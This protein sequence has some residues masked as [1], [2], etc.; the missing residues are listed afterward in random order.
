LR[1]GVFSKEESTR[2]E[3]DGLL[4]RVYRSHSTSAPRSVPTTLGQIIIDKN[5][6][7]TATEI[8]RA[9]KRLD[10]E[11]KKCG[12]QGDVTSGGF[13]YTQ[14]TSELARA[15]Q[16]QLIRE[17]QS[18]PHFLNAQA[19]G[20]FESV[21]IGNAQAR[22]VQGQLLARLQRLADE[23]NYEFARKH[24]EQIRS[25]VF[26][27]A[28]AHEAIG[29]AYSYQNDEELIAKE[30]TLMGLGL[31]SS[32]E[33][34]IREHARESKA[35][36]RRLDRVY[37]GERV[38]SEDGEIVWSAHGV[39]DARVHRAAFGYCE[40][41][42]RIQADYHQRAIIELDNGVIASVTVKRAHSDLEGYVDEVVDN[43]TWY[44]QQ[45][46]KAEQTEVA[47]RKLLR[48]WVREHATATTSP[49]SHTESRD[50]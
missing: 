23:R 39:A 42:A 31:P 41:A 8:A 30:A 16:A 32:H 44:R 7:P 4:Q 13:A 28:E 12:V 50:T 38:V 37:A 5:R 22:A 17:R 35:L 49:T 11:L 43:E 36:R 10:T 15:R 14:P 46:V 48:R 9:A 33:Q 21:R 24:V 47:A 18:I 26:S 40:A 19:R 25:G 20:H 3:R 2:L 29:I 6:L 34:T 27:R 1:E 45:L